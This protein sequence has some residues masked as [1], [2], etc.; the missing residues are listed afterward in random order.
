MQITLDIPDDIAQQ[1]Q[2]LQEDLPQILALG[3]QQLNANPSTGLSGL[4]EILEF[5]GSTP[6]PA[7]NP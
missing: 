6:Q 1:L 2:P 3:I 7:T 5:F 4:T